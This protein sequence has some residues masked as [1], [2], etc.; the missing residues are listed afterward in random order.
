MAQQQKQST[1]VINAAQSF[2]LVKNMIRISVSSICYIRNL[3][4]AEC[5]SSKDYAGISVRQ[6]ES[7]EPGPDGEL[8]V[9]NKDAFMITQWLE[10]GVFDAIEK[11]YVTKLSHIPPINR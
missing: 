2:V 9:K 10:K 4:P 1:D 7:A 5:F 6:L 11:R 3:F 8:R